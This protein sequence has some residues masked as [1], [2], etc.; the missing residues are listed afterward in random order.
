MKIFFLD[1]SAL[2]KRYVNETGSQWLRTI[3]DPASQNRLMIA[4]ITWVE[5]LSAFARL[6]RD[7]KLSL[8][9]ADLAVRIFKYDWNTQYQ[10]IEMDS[11]LAEVAGELVQRYPLRAYDSVQLASA[12][13][14]YSFLSQ[15]QPSVFVFVSADNRLNDVARS[16]G[17]QVQNPNEH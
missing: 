2:A 4:R 11:T 16:E 5:I 3:I 15:I 7:G 10:V 6:K 12:L 14:I 13:R 8:S 1:T 9:E 17:L